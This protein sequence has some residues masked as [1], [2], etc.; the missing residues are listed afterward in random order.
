M[1]EPLHPGFIVKEALIDGAKLSVTQASERLGVTRTTLSR[2]LNGHSS[3]SPE[4]A[5]RL[6]KLFDT[7]IEMWMSLQSHYDIWLIKQRANEL[8]VEKLKVA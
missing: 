3:I 8:K 5:L 4:M 7:S 2:L 1:Y 6:S